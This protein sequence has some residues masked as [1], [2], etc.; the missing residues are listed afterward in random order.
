MRIIPTWGEILREIEAQKRELI[1]SH[2]NPLL[3]F[4]NVRRKYLAQLCAVTKRNAVIYASKWTTPG[5]P[6]EL[7]SI[8]EEDVH[9]LMEVFH[10]LKGSSLDL[11]VHSPGGSPESAEAMV[12]YLRSKFDDIRV[13]IPQAAMSAATM[14]ACSSDRIMMGKHSSIGP[15]DPQMI[16]ETPL[17]PQAVPA[18]AIIDQFR[19]AQRECQNPALLGSWLPM[20]GQY[21][22]AL[23]VECD[24][25]LKLSKDLVTRWLSRYMFRNESDSDSRASMIAGALTDHN[26]FKSHGR[27][28]SR[29]QAR[30]LG[31][32]GLVVDDLEIDQKTQDAV[33]SVFHATIHTFNGTSAVKLLEN[34]L[35]RAYV[36]SVQMLLVQPS[37]Q[38]GPGGSL[39][40]GILPAGGGKPPE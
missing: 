20:L 26:S 37:G 23:L 11:I 3:A 5:A 16:V 1:K 34:H 9:G 35:G 17:G 8:N 25:A 22:P 24:E 21:G 12:S 15:I 27:H 30:T 10:G 6:P 38:S 18:Q 31:G 4:D 32:K 33:L 28:I 13:I 29:D 40:L 2:E 39:P 19:M 14:L 7:I 36:K